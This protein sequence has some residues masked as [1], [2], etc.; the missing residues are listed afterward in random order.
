MWGNGKSS[1]LYVLYGTILYF[2]SSGRLSSLRM[3]SLSWSMSPAS[4][5]PWDST[6]CLDTGAIRARSRSRQKQCAYSQ[7]GNMPSGEG[8]KYVP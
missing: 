6:H 8:G 7:F 1:M 4:T 3:K 2:R 5:A